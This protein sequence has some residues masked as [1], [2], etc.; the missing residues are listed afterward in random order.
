MVRE[1]L[2]APHP[3]AAR[4]YSRRKDMVTVEPVRRISLVRRGGIARDGGRIDI[5]V[6]R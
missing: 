2:T 3:R 1:S 6:T 5:Q 4:G